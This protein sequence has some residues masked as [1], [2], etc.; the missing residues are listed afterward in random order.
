MNFEKNIEI[1][2]SSDA[3]ARKYL[4]AD[5]ETRTIM[6]KTLLKSLTKNKDTESFKKRKIE[7]DEEDT[8]EEPQ[9]I[10]RTK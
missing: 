4:K 10:K 6:Y 3:H 8:F 1:S 7:N 2:V 9:R 5:K